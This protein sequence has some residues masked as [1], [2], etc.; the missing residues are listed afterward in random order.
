MEALGGYPSKASSSRPRL[1]SLI[2]TVTLCISSLYLLHAKIS[3]NRKHASF[4][5]FH[6]TDTK[7]RSVSLDKYRGKYGDTEP[8]TGR[9]AEAFARSNYAVTFPFFN[10]IK[11][12]G[13]EVEPAFRFL[14]DSVQQ[15]PKW[16]FWKFLV[17]AE[18]QVL[19]V[20][21]PEEPMEEIRK[22][23]TALVREIILKKRHEL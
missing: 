20:W 1:M 6:V 7:G 8:G 21:K 2:I 17:S 14:T 23:A 9:D 19:R 4:Y 5:S 16:N 13:S 10:M 3:R 12:M 18:G 22:E 11:I 15:I